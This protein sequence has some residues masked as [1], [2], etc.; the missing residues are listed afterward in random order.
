M[1]SY[2]LSLAIRSL[3]RN[4]VLTA[5]M[6]FIGRTRA[7]AEEKQARHNAL[8][9]PIVGL[10]TLSSHMNVDFSGYALD[11]P[12][13]DLEV[14]GMQGLFSL[15]RELSAERQ[16]TLADVGRLYASG[17]LVP[18]VAGTAADI[19]DWMGHIVGKQGAD[20]FVITPVHLPSG[21]DDFVEQ[22]VPELQR[23]G[24][25]RLDYRGDTLRSYLQD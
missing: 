25:F 21:F 5:L 13:A 1:F 14:A 3:R 24:Q 19:A 11:A 20:G 18:Q 10:S 17:V 6:P 23:R 8:V 7:E 12:I 15:I 9:D 2:Y 22:V 16:L 4:K